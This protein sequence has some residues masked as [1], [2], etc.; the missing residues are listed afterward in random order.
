[1]RSDPQP[2]GNLL[3]SYGA[4]AAWTY[5]R[6]VAFSGAELVVTLGCSQYIQSRDDWKLDI[7]E[8]SPAPFAS[9]RRFS[10]ADGR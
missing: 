10:S 1:M 5:G 9:N 3:I 4:L 8:K 7:P 2:A 6:I